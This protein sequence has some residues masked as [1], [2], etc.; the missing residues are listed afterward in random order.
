LVLRGV[1]GRQDEG[2][3][4][5]QTAEDD[6]FDRIAHENEMKSGQPYHFDVYVSPSQRNQVLEEIAIK[7]AALPFGD[8]A[9]SFACYVRDMKA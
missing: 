6:E 8:T 9:A 1:L 4:M 2:K 7:L 3:E 5:I